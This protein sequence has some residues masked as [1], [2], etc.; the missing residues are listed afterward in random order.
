MAAQAALAGGLDVTLYEAM[1]SVGRKFLLAGRGGLNLS[2]SEP[3]PAFC[4]RY[5]EAAPWLRPRLEAFDAAAV[6]RWCESLG[7]GTFVGT[8]GRIFPTDFKAAPLLRAWLHQLKESG[9]HVRVRHRLTRLSA[10][11]TLHLETPHGPESVT[12][13]A[14]ILALGGGSW[15]HLGSDG[16]WVEPLR[17]LGVPVAA[18]RPSNCGFHVA[19][20]PYF[21]DRF[22]GAPV[23][24]VRA[25]T[26]DVDGQPVEAMGELTVTATGIEGGL[27]YQ[28][29]AP[30]RHALETRGTATLQLDLVPGRTLELVRAALAKPRG[31][32]SFSRHLESVVGLKGVKVALLHEVLDRDALTDLGRV[33]AT[34]KALPITVTATRPLDEA[35]SS[36]GGIGLDALDGGQMIQSLPGVFC[37]GEMLDW[38]APTGGYLLTAC[39]ATGV[40]AAQG[41]LAWLARDTDGMAP[42]DPPV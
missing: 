42:E 39:F 3:F 14:V 23:K 5:R 4:G 8:S 29:S 25:S 16:S 22:A 36:A 31:R 30:L 17:A 34:L 13:D 19:W 32:K 10:P 20:S 15:P 38:E 28:L 41:A 40:A 6:V 12:P 18:L 2:H 37:A 26:T 1:P 27:V 35:I 11:R 21:A 7:I 24:S 9:L 33:A